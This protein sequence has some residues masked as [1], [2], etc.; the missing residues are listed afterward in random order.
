M[1]IIKAVILATALLVV[2]G[3]ALASNFGDM[4]IS[5]IE[6]DVQVKTPDAGDWG[7]HR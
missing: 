7:P 2:P 3:Y 6:G 1:S 5:L 4:R